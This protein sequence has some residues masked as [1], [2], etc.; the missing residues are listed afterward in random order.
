MLCGRCLGRGTGSALSGLGVMFLGIQFVTRPSLRRG[1]IPSRTIG[2]G[3]SYGLS[4]LD[5][6]NFGTNLHPPATI[7][8]CPGSGPF[9]YNTSPTPG[10]LDAS[11][12]SRFKVLVL[13]GKFDYFKEN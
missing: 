8:A 10:G 5:G 7:S 4:H 3:A 13:G 12:I 9:N 11:R 1:T 2:A 6:K